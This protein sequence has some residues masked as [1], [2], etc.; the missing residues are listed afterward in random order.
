MTQNE[1]RTGGYNPWMTKY[2]EDICKKKQCSP[3]R[4]KLRNREDVDLTKKQNSDLND[5]QQ[6][7][8][9]KSLQP[10]QQ[11]VCDIKKREF[12][13]AT[14]I[15]NANNEDQ[16]YKVMTWGYEAPVKQD[17]TKDNASISNKIRKMGR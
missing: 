10:G 8:F 7:E 4:D 3:I 11:T 6:V 14:Q 17:Y 16:I 13:S 1:G 5:A 15:K 9:L 12:K 2:A